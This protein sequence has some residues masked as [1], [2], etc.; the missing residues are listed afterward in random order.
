MN[1]VKCLNRCAFWVSGVLILQIVVL[2]FLLTNLSS[3]FPEVD[4][5]NEAENDL[6]LVKS[7][8]NALVLLFNSR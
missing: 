3:I 6:D 7:A 5:E 2:V 4:E 1:H 8:D